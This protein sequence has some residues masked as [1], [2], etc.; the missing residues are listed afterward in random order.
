MKSCSLPMTLLRT[1][2]GK[3]TPNN[4]EY[5]EAIFAALRLKA[6]RQVELVTPHQHEDV[7]RLYS[8]ILDIQ[9]VQEKISRERYR[10]STSRQ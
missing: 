9:A 4:I 3:E 2:L 1:T 5:G 7:I 6:Q 10:L 8:L